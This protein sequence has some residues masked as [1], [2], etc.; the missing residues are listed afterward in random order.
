[1]KQAE[2][3]AEYGQ[4]NY[5]DGFEEV[6]TGLPIDEQLRFFRIGNG[7]YLKTEWLLR[8][9][10]PYDGADLP[11]EKNVEAIIVH[12]DKIAGVM[13]WDE[14]SNKI[15]PCL[16]ERRYCCRYDTELDGSGYKDFIL[17][18][19]LICVSENFDCE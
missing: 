3:K 4:I 6:I 7:L 10:N 14:M 12:E 19:Y 13:V 18:S 5:P 2:Y 17:Y 1:M 9:K 15:V 11:D 16:P 8:R